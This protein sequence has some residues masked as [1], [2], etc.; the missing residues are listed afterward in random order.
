M[1]GEPK[2]PRGKWLSGVPAIT[3]AMMAAYQGSHYATAEVVHRPG[4]C[5]LCCTHVIAGKEAPEWIDG[6][7]FWL[8]YRIDELIGVN[9]YNWR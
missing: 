5:C 1:S 9:P 8:A 4:Y 6:D 2:K 7:F 3:V